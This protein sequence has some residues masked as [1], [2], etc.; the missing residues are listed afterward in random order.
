[1][2]DSSQLLVSLPESS[3]MAFTLSSSVAALADD[4][5]AFTILK[6]KNQYL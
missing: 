4:G 3:A 2:S 1:M 6:G 5:I